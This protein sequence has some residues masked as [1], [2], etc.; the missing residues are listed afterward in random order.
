MPLETEED[1]EDLP[2]ICFIYTTTSSGP[3]HAGIHGIFNDP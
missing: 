1:Q 3:P 2:I